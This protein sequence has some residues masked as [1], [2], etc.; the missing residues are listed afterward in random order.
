MQLVRLA[1]QSRMDS[2]IN[3]YIQTAAWVYT[4]PLLFLTPG[5]CLYIAQ[6]A[7]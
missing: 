6:I 1:P 2:T 5:T 4:T 3:R 7:V